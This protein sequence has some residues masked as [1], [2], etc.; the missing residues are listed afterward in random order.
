MGEVA[1]T[2][3]RHCALGLAVNGNARPAR[4]V[5]SGWVD[6]RGIRLES[7]IAASLTNLQRTVGI[8]D[9]SPSGWA[10]TPKALA[11]WDRWRAEQTR[12]A[13]QL[14]AAWAADPW[15]TSGSELAELLENVLVD[16][17]GPRP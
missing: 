7:A 6:R 13:R 10:P 15:T 4:R 11:L 9:P 17:K 5:S 14:A 2:R 3:L 16:G 8:V 12:Q 1:W